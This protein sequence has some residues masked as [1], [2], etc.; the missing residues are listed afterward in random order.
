MS[1][2]TVAKSL[3]LL[4]PSEG[5]D[6]IDIAGA[7]VTILASSED[8][9]GTLSVLRYTAPAGFRGPPLHIHPSFDEAWYVLEGELTMMPEGR[10]TTLRPGAFAFTPGAV[11]HTFANRTD[12]PTT[13]LIICTPGGFE[14]YF[15]RL[16][17]L[18]V[19]G[20]PSFETI[21]AL[22]ARYGSE[23]A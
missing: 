14:R 20:A 15:R 8:T 2:T 18:S 1:T 9:A 4:E 23:L 21:G 17:E 7:Q 11:P 6:A 16:T 12:Q 13:F 5:E 19:G 10:P 22:A 3:V